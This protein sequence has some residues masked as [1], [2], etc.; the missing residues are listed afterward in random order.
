MKAAILAGIVVLAMV[1]AASAQAVETAQ[2]VWM[3][4]DGESNIEILP[5]GDTL[6]GRIV[7]LREPT[8]SDGSPKTDVNNPKRELRG[9]PIMGLTILTGLRPT[10]GK[11][12][13]LEGTVY[14]AR[15]GELYDIYLQP[16]GATMKVEGCA[17]Y[18][19]CG[20]QTWQRLR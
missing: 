17:V 13:Q 15:N 4:Q 18:I 8:N 5:C 3:D 16:A 19:L 1:D 7:W 20:S 12:Q 10:S 14:N 2:G 11:P 9:Q 6:C